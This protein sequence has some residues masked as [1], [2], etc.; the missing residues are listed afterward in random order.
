MYILYNPA[1]HHQPGF[2]SHCSNLFSISFGFPEEKCMGHS[3]SSRA[4]FSDVFRVKTQLFVQST[5]SLYIYLHIH[6]N[7]I[8]VHYDLLTE[9]L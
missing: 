8:T 7:I 6:K 5:C 1:T 4:C 9:P 2:C 3:T